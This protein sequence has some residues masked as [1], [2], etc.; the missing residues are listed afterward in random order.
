MTGG[1]GLPDEAISL[2]AALH[3]SG[4]RHVV[5]TQW[6]VDARAAERF[7][8]SVHTALA[9]DGGYTP[10]RA[11]AAV[12]GAALRLRADTGLPRFSWTPFTHTGP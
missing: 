9:S 10:E 5:G 11:A 6:S 4:Y 1:R 3:Y 8:A 2:G 7:G 12:R